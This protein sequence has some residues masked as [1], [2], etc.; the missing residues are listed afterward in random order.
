MNTSKEQ[1]LFEL[2]GRFIE[3]VGGNPAPLIQSECR[4][5]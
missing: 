5:R 1:W 2:E 3:I 4:G